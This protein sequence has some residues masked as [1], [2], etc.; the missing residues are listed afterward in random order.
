MKRGILDLTAC[1]LPWYPDGVTRVLPV[2]VGIHEKDLDLISSE[3]PGYDKIIE[4]AKGHKS[5]HVRKNWGLPIGL[6][7][8]ALPVGAVLRV[9]K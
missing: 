7:L 1:D 9:T 8:S 2:E 5:N 6:D 4:V 3:I